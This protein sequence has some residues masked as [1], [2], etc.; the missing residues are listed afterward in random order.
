MHIGP[1]YEQAL[2]LT[3]K[4][5]RIAALLLVGDES[6]PPSLRHSLSIALSAC[7]AHDG[8]PP[9]HD[10]PEAVSARRFVAAC[11][12]VSRGMSGEYRR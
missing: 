5:A 10:D 7:A 4:A 1:L 12:E 2:K 6:I 8:E 11:Q 3:P 9:A